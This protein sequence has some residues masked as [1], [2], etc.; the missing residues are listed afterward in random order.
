[1]STVIK[2]YECPECG[3]IEIVQSHTEI[4]KKCPECKSIIDRVLS[5][6]L[7]AK[8]GSP[9]TVGGLLDKNNKRNPLE[10]EKIMG[11]VTEKKLD[12]ISRSRKLATASPE[13]IK[14]YVETGIL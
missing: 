10:R 12:A 6:P 4:S 1:M 5:A 14:R 9:K 13:V 3:D 11:D 7:V 8:D 2:T